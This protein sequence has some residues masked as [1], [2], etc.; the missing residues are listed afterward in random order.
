MTATLPV[1]VKRAS[2]LRGLTFGNAIDDNLLSC[3]LAHNSFSFLYGEN[4]GRTMN[5]LCANAVRVFGGVAVFVDASN[6]ADP[7]L[8]VRLAKKHR[9]AS[10]QT[11]E[12]VLDSIV[13]LRAFTPYQL[14]DIVARQ[15]G[16]LIKERKPVSI[17][18]SGLGSVFN[19]QDHSKD[20]TQKLQSLMASRLRDISDDHTNGIQFVVA[21]S[22]SYSERFVSESQTVIRFF[23]QKALLMK[24]NSAM[25]HAAVEL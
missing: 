12:N 1:A 7:Y 11:I 23:D 25:Q 10:G 13:L 18:V 17:F 2:E 16:R 19:E 20:E 14:Y 3:G 6:S 8:I 5:V 22:N 24:S 15:I 21:S 9:K 4:T